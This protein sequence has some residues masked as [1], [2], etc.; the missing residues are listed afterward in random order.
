MQDMDVKRVR[1]DTSNVELGSIIQRINKSASKERQLRITGNKGE[2]LRRAWDYF[3][4]PHQLT[5]VQQPIIRAKKKKKTVLDI[6]WDIIQAQ[7]IGR[8]YE[9]WKKADDGQGI[10]QKYVKHKDW[11]MWSDND[12]ECSNC[13]QKL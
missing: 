7:N 8:I 10:V 12:C 9:E 11:D 13:R 6:P 5:A 2:L 3:G 4:M 1:W